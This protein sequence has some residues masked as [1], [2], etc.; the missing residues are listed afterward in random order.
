MTSPADPTLFWPLIDRARTSSGEDLAGFSDALRELLRAQSNEQI[1]AFDDQLGRLMDRAYTW[2]LWGA[3]YVINRGCSD[4]SFAYFRAWLVA[5]G[6]TVFEQAL[7]D[8]D[9][10][11]E[12]PLVL[13]DGETELESLLSLAWSLYEERTG[14]YPPATGEE[15]PVPDPSGR[16]WDEDDLATLFP[17]LTARY[18]C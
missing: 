8:P 11:A 13:N 14:Q 3:A 17:N 12:L 18:G 7:K 4:D 2:P 15:Q 5:Q 1:A 16:R 9:S 10:L 6:E